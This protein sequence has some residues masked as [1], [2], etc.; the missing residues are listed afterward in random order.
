MNLIGVLNLELDY[1]LRQ[2]SVLLVQATAFFEGGW[3]LGL[4][5]LLKP[6]EF[7]VLEICLALARCAQI[8]LWGTLDPTSL[9]LVEKGVLDVHVKMVR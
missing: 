6:V 9:L 2:Y 3:T 4:M 5:G 7:W 8:L 1:V